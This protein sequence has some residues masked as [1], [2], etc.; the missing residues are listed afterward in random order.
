MAA[1]GETEE[2]FCGFLQPV[3]NLC[4]FWDDVRGGTEALRAHPDFQVIE[5]D[6]RYVCF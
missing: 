5:E 1:E 2:C 6:P 4:M 3:V